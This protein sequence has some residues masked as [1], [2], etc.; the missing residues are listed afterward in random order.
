MSEMSDAYSHTIAVAGNRYDGQIGPRGFRARGHRQR[1]A[2]KRVD[3]VGLCEKGITSRA[4]Y[5][6]NNAQFM[7]LY[8]QL[9]NRFG[10]GCRDP[11]VATARAPGRKLSRAIVEDAGLL[12]RFYLF[13][14]IMNVCFSCSLL[15]VHGYSPS[16]R[17][18]SSRIST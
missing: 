17:W 8:A 6:R 10:Q 12:N 11:E 14:K 3:A 9:V 18:I 4:A 13:V 5:P 1:A 15:F 16:R 7:S 2:M